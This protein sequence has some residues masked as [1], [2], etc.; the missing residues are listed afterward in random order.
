MF[1]AY[2]NLFRGTG[3][4]LLCM[5]FG[6]LN[7][8]SDGMHYGWTAPTIPILL[9][10][11]SPIKITQND[12]VW[13]EALYMIFGLVSLPLTVYLADKIGRQKSV[14]V[15]SA[16]SLIGWTLIGTAT[17]VEYLYIARSLVGAA[18]DVAFVCS[19]MYV[20]EIAHEK[21]RGFL[22]GTIYVM[23]LG[24]V[25]LIY[26]IAPFVSIRI[27][28]I[29]GACIVTTQLIIF[30]FMP[31]SPYFHLYKGKEE[32]ARKSLRFLRGTD[33]IDEEFKA[34]HSAIERQKAEKG[35]LQDLI[36]VKSNRRAIWVMTILN[37]GQH[38]IGFSAILMNLH[39]ILSAAD[40]TFVS[41][42]SAAIVYSGI[43]MLASIVASLIVD[44][45][46][47]K[48]LVNISCITAGLCLLGIGVF[49][50]LKASGVD[51]KALSW[52]PI[53]FIMF[54]AAF[55]KFGIGTIPI[56]MTAEIFSAK[57]KAL[58]MSVADGMYVFFSTVSIYAY[59]WLNETYGMHFVFYMFSAF[60]ASTFIL[61]MIFIPETKGKTLEEI[62]LMLKK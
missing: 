21:I 19:P 1:K 40:V 29:V 58:G 44:K 24:G 36:L 59:Q 5:L 46:G 25:F 13:L 42:D 39:T 61:T 43:M 22:A 48:V 60:S 38:M 33:D 49:F 14:L 6:T 17:R 31:E 16:T 52:I 50:Q 18:A 3:P 37:C 23:E 57:V 55:F 47:R 20:A 8:L 26:C 9:E 62:Q 41:S 2:V 10:E 11:D 54:Y 28:P 12:V 53:V 51:V 34:I 45:F 7:A 15:A 30:P 32:A 35:R 56:V 4:Q 27:P